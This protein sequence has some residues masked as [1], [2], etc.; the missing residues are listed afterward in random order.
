MKEIARIIS[1]P[2]A[3]VTQVAALELRRQLA[4]AQNLR[5]RHELFGPDRRIFQDGSSAMAGSPIFD[6]SV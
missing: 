6:S 2:E 4:R 5:R 3:D 1:I